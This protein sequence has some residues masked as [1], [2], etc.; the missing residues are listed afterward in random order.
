MHVVLAALFFF[1]IL[2]LWVP[3]YWP[4]AVFQVGVFALAVSALAVYGIRRM[5]LSDLYPVVP[6]SFA[7][8]WGLFQWGT[9]RTAYG[10]DTKTAIVHDPMPHASPIRV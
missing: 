2:T 3:A 5:R 8:V 4:V 9:G 1:A 7:V 10:F 6:L